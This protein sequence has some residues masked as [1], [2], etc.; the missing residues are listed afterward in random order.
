MRL[1]LH[2]DAWLHWF[3]SGGTLVGM[4]FDLRIGVGTDTHAFSS[5][6]S[7]PMWLACLLWPGEVGCA[8]HSDADVVAH[9]CCDAL[10][11]AADLGDLGTNFGTDRPEYAGASGETLLRETL[12][13]LSSSGWRPVN[14]SVQLI[15]NRPR[16]GDRRE[17]ASTQLSS[18]VGVPVSFS[19]TTTDGLGFTG[20]GEGLAAVATALVTR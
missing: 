20:R 1:R 19:A 13:I 14:V 16:I 2:L 17:E 18:I 9:A 3:W 12:R 5:D 11:A 4:G 10:L 7:R 6:T 8:G 15:G